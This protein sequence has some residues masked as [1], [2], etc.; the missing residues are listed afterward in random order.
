MGKDIR[1]P[2]YICP[3][4]LEA[5]HDRISEKIRAK[6]KLDGEPLEEYIKP[7]GGGYFFTLPGVPAPG[8][9]FAQTLLEAV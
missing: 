8:H 1:S 4:N 6:K 5:E 9:Y 7:F 3:D 2:H